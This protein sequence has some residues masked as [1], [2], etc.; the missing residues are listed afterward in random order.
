MWSTLGQAVR[1]ALTPS[2]DLLRTEAF[3]RLEIPVLSVG[4]SLDRFPSLTSTIL[5]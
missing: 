2:Q 3:H 1:S 5:T 4:E